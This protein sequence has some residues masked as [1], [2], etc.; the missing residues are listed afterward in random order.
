MISFINPNRRR[1]LAAI[2]YTAGLGSMSWNASAQS[3]PT[4]PVRVVVPF[5]PGGATDILARLI[6]AELTIALGQAFTVDNVSG[7]GGNIG[8]NQVAKAAADGHTLLF[9]AAGNLTI[10]PGL[11]ANMPY[12]PV[13][14]LAPVSLM[15]STMNVLVAH[16]AVNAR[17]VRELI[18]LAKEQPDKL[19]YASAGNGSTIHLAAEMFK[20]MARVNV[21]GVPYRGSGPAM[22]DLL[23]GRT[24]IMFENMPSALPHIQ[25]GALRAIGVTGKVRSDLLPTVPTIAEAGVP[26]FEAT[27]WFGVLAPARTPAP[28]IDRLYRSI[29]DAMKKPEIIEKVRKLGAEVSLNSPDEFRQLIRTDTEKWG[30]IIKAAGIKLD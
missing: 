26:G 11:F 28:V 1:A 18:A 10:N 19:T 7:G 23:A 3:Y 24:N 14:D 25:S 13:S 20:S 17:S 22:I 30:I 4:R 21:L 9:G 29:T 6:S 8:S 27:S 15:A 2:A 12:D 5:A 16:P